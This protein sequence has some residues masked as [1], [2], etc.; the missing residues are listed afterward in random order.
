[1]EAQVVSAH[2]GPDRDRHSRPLSCELARLAELAARTTGPD[3]ALEARIATVLDAVG[4]RPALTALVSVAA[5]PALPLP[6]R[7]AV[8]AALHRAVR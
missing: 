4:D 1:V 7:V 5:D 8:L 3:P 6:R 2:R